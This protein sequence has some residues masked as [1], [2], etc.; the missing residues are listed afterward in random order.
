MG[1]SVLPPP[2]V[3]VA[4]E[5]LRRRCLTPYL[6]VAIARRISRNVFPPRSK[7]CLQLEAVPGAEGMTG[8]RATR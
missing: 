4:A 5:I 7:Y 6:C 3:K 2:K 8:L 1:A